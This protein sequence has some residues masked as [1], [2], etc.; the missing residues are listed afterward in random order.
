MEYPPEVWSSL[1]TFG[2]S[3][4]PLPQLSPTVVQKGSNKGQ[5]LPG[6][7]IVGAGLYVQISGE[8][9]AGL[10]DRQQTTTA[11]WV[12]SHVWLRR[13]SWRLP[14]VPWRPDQ[15]LAPRHHRVLGGCGGSELDLFMHADPAVPAGYRL[16]RCHVEQL[17][18]SAARSG[19]HCGYLGSG[20]PCRETGESRWERRAWSC[21]GCTKRGEH[22]RAVWI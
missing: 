9:V 7:Y 19:R 16:R 10:F 8:H 14:A 20:D 12:W 22:D 13:A 4:V 15:R 6:R 17:G 21:C 2:T 1:L 3:V 11:L 5:Q 18:A